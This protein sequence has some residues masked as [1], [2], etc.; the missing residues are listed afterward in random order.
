MGNKWWLLRQLKRERR[1]DSALSNHFFHL[2]TY[3]YKAQLNAWPSYWNIAQDVDPDWVIGKT[4]NSTLFLSL[5]Q[6]FVKHSRWRSTVVVPTP[7]GTPVTPSVT[8]NA[9]PSTKAL[10]YQTAAQTPIRSASL[11]LTD[12]IL[13]YIQPRLRLECVCVC[14]SAAFLEFPPAHFIDFC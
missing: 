6:S 2:T 13:L 12:P 9:S 10:R 5:Q 1:F 8:P 3:S 7:N 14:F 4:L 11:W